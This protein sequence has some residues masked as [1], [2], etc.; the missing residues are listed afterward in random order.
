MK[1]T[2]GKVQMCQEWASK[3]NLYLLFN[4]RRRKTVLYTHEVNPCAFDHRD[5]EDVVS[6]ILDLL[7]KAGGFNHHL[8][9]I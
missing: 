1:D 6:I 7:N 5:T 3:F 9:I 8:N 2:G 4:K